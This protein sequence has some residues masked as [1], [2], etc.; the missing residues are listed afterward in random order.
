MPF[1]QPFLA[2]GERF[3]KNTSSSKILLIRLKPCNSALGQPLS[4]RLSES[5]WVD[6]LN[7]HRWRGQWL[8]MV[9]MFAG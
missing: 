1:W 3:V 7:Q 4:K 8:A 5:D 2:A 6:P 9:M